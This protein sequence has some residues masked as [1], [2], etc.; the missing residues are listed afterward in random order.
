MKFYIWEIRILCFI[1]LYTIWTE[2]QYVCVYLL[3]SLFK[4]FWNPYK[5]KIHIISIKMRFKIY[6]NVKDIEINSLFKFKKIQW[7][8]YAIV[9]N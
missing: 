7:I 1:Y 5:I 9:L 6:R 2:I 3:N 4:L 8:K